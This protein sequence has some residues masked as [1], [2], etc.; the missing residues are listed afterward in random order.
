MIFDASAHYA[1][2]EMELGIWRREVV[3]FGKAYFR[4]YLRNFPPS[5]PVEQWDDR[6]RL[7]CMKY[8]LSHSMAWPASAESI[9]ELYV[10]SIIRRSLIN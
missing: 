2:N 4:Q 9:R 5:E 6:N 7:Y 10:Y 3:R 1:H 8:H